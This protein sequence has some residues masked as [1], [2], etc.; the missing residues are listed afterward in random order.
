VGLALLD[1][2][3]ERRRVELG[4]ELPLLDAAVEVGVEAGDH[5]GDL[6]ADLN[7]R[8]GRERAGGGDGLGDVAAVDLLGLVLF[9]FLSTAAAGAGQDGQAQ[10]DCETSHSGSPSKART[11]TGGRLC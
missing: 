1:L 9:V 4:E 11:T 8:H 5:A 10:D 2:G 6:A 7:G 3:L